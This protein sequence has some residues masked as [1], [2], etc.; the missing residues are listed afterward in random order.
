[1]SSVDQ[2]SLLTCM[3]RLQRA[4]SYILADLLLGSEWNACSREQLIEH[5]VGWILNAGFPQ[6]NNH[7]ISEIDNYQY[8]ALEIDEC[9]QEQWTQVLESSFIF[10]DRARASGRTCLVH[11]KLGDSKAPILVIAYLIY[12]TKCSLREA[13]QHCIA[14]RRTVD[15]PAALLSQLISFEKEILGMSSLDQKISEASCGRKVLTAE[16]VGLKY[17]SL[18]PPLSRLILKVHSE[19]FVE[20]FQDLLFHDQWEELGKITRTLKE[21]RYFLR[22]V[23]RTLYRF[24][25]SIATDF[26]K[27]VVAEQKLTYSQKIE[28]VLEWMKK[29][30]RLVNEHFGSRNGFQHAVNQ[31]LQY[32]AR[33]SV[34]Q[35]FLQNL[36]SFIHAVMSKRSSQHIKDG[37]QFFHSE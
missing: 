25:K 37:S 1:M 36:A 14:M 2:D 28:N 27:Q 9:N 21:D 30:Q 19:D 31:G 8:L 13:L 32:I 24:S 4:P 12:K 33:T 18:I 3:D 17:E 10:I 5:N 16:V 22:V 29:Y 35:Q 34:S 11:D 7:F 20:K 6:C 26:I 15:P 23:R